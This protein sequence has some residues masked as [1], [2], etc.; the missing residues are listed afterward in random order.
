MNVLKRNRRTRSANNLCKNV[1]NTKISKLSNTIV[2]QYR[3]R[4][5]L[6]EN[7]VYRSNKRLRKSVDQ[8]DMKQG[9]RSHWDEKTIPHRKV[10][11]HLTKAE[12]DVPI[13]V[14]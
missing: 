7:V 6:T 10:Q 4:K 3:Y 2:N 13:N 14:M 1:G 5:K 9:P 8:K 11:F 12:L